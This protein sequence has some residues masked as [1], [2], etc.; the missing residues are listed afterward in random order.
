M[1]KEAKCH[2]KSYSQIFKSWIKLLQVINI[3]KMETLIYS[4]QD[5]YKFSNIPQFQVLSFQQFSIKKFT[6]KIT[7]YKLV[8]TNYNAYN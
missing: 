5:I 1:K 7:L 6:L 2:F 3:R 4:C 8:E